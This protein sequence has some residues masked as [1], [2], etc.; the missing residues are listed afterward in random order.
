MIYNI[1]LRTPQHNWG[2]INELRATVMM[3]THLFTMIYGI[4]TAQKAARQTVSTS[5]HFE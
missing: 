5:K 4:K 2:S 1:T 3:K